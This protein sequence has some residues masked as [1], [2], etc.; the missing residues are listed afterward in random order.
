VT[1]LLFILFLKYFQ[2]FIIKKPNI[3]SISQNEIKNFCI[4]DIFYLPNMNTIFCAHEDSAKTDTLNFNFIEREHFGLISVYSY[5]NSET[6]VIN[7]IPII[8]RISKILATNSGNLIIGS[9]EGKISILN[10]DIIFG[11]KKFSQNFVAI[12]MSRIIGLEWVLQDKIFIGISRDNHIKIYDIEKHVLVGGGSIGK[13]L[14]NANLT[15]MTY[16][17][18][19]SRIFVGTD[20]N[21]VHIYQVK[22]EANTY[23]P[24]HIHSLQLEIENPINSLIFDNL[25]FNEINVKGKKCC[26]L[27]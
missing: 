5:L 2:E 4:T 10:E 23:N 25:Y 26:I 13:R 24:K 3:I 19:N 22:N 18:K 7:T 9:D 16:D 21:S 27:E 12:F 14:K 11:K 6:K 15:C 17:A 1:N 8:P 20:K